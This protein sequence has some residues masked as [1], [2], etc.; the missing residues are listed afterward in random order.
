MNGFKDGFNNRA[1]L[2]NDDFVSP[3]RDSVREGSLNQT[4]STYRHNPDS[5]TL[6]V[7]RNKG[8]E[9]HPDYKGSYMPPPC[10]K[11]GHVAEQREIAAWWRN[12]KGSDGQDTKSQ[13]LG[14]KTSDKW[15]PSSPRNDAEENSNTQPAKNDFDSDIPF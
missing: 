8:A 9:T 15:Q 10:A 11:C 7:N 2:R 14:V 3:T 13:F 4:P 12:K 1:P 6:F 5:G